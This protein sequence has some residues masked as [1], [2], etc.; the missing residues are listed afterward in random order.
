MFGY[1]CVVMRDE[2]F[3]SCRNSQMA[4]GAV[5]VPLVRYWAFSQQCTRLFITLHLW[6]SSPTVRPL[7]I[8][9]S[10]AC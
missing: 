2:R 5:H 6:Y 4:T 8:G 10:K 9:S 1:P 3:R 7:E